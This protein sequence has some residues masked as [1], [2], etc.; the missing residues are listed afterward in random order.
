MLRVMLL[1]IL[2]VPALAVDDERYVE[3]AALPKIPKLHTPERAG[4]D[5]P[6]PHKQLTN[7]NHTVLGYVNGMTFGTDYVGILKKPG[8]VF[9]GLWPRKEK[10]FSNKYATDGPIHVPDLIALQ[11]IRR[12][13]KDAR[14][15][16]AESREEHKTEG[17]GEHK[18][19]DHK[20]HKA[21]PGKSEHKPEPRK[22]GG[23]PVE[24]LDH[25]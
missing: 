10:S 20:D 18:A 4:I 17:H 11:P 2:A 19:E 1:L 21:E 7:T 13:I 12:A 22:D 24:K 3:R 14:E 8:R 9:P 25:Q 15:K 6:A 5:N 23:A 16:K